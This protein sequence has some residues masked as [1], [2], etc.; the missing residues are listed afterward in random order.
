M[1]GMMHNHHLSHGGLKN[2]WGHH[3]ASSLNLSPAAT[4][5]AAAYASYNVNSMH[6]QQI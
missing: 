2:E 5:A 3:A 1:L 4:L 6:Q